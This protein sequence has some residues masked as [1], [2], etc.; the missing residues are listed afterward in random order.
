MKIIGTLLLLT[1][2]LAGVCAAQDDTAKF[3]YRAGK[4]VPVGTVL[5]YVKTNLDG[6]RP[7]YVSQFVAA[8]DR[9]ES[10]KFHPKSPPAG[11]VIAT[12]DWKFFAARSL[13]SWRVPGR[14]ERTLFGTLT[15]DAA[16]RRAE[17]SLPAVRPAAE[18]FAFGQL[19]I[20]LYN[21]DFGSLNF[22][23]PH[24]S[25]P[26]GGFRIG[27]ADPT[28]KESGPLVEYKGAVTVSYLND[29]RRAN[30]PVRK[31][32]IDGAGLQNRGG[33]IWV[34]RRRG[35][36]EDME[37]DLPDNPEWTSFKF[38]LLR[39]ERM[40]RARWEKFIESQF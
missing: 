28:F 22:A 15:F 37:I 29:E 14:G 5:H 25:D 21:F 39:V 30:V 32:R 33:F 3:R 27:V 17:V 36:I 10:F 2:A 12:M 4:A 9:L 6:S 38:K 34:N 8:A 35:W 7:E 20:H 26:E 16:A 13:K 31:Y 18:T 11:L 19:P 24:L 40:S 1:A 23:L